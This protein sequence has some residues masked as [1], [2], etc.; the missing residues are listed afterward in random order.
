MENHLQDAPQQQPATDQTILPESLQLAKLMETLVT[1]SRAQTADFLEAMRLR[2]E[3]SIRIG[4]RTTQVIRF[5]LAALVTMGVAMFVLILTLIV[6]MDNITHRMDDM[7][8]LMASMN[9][10]F[11]QVAFNVNS[12]DG[13]IGMINGQFGVLTNQMGYM[14]RDVN[15]MSSPMRFMPFRP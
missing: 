9:K 10:D 3:L 6:H 1:E 14:T 12:M 4:R 5:S 13:K 2:E 7:T 15:T 11:D 8:K